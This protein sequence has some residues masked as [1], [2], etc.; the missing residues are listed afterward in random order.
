MVCDPASALI[1]T[2]LAPLWA[3]LLGALLFDEPVSGRTLGALALALTSVV[4]AFA[5]AALG[6]VPQKMGLLK[7][8]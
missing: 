6:V 7:R 3:A 4:I 1:L 8:I 5:P 2:S